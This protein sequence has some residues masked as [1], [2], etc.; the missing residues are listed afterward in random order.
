MF[1]NLFKKGTGVLDQ[2]KLQA[3]LAPIPDGPIPDGAELPDGGGEP[4]LI[5]IDRR[6]RVFQILNADVENGKF[7]QVAKGRTELLKLMDMFDVQ[8]RPD[9]VVKD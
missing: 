1:N 5:A 2:L 3:R 9:F 4:I 8:D 7:M 6:G